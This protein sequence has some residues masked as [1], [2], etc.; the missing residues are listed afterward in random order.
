[1][2]DFEKQFTLAFFT[3]Y[4]RILFENKYVDKLNSMSLSKRVKII[5][6]I[7]QKYRSVTYGSTGWNIL[8]VLFHY[9]KDYGSKMKNEVFSPYRHEVYCIDDK[10]VIRNVYSSTQHIDLYTVEEYNKEIS[11]KPLNGFVTIG[12]LINA[13]RKLDSSINIYIDYKR[14]PDGNYTSIHLDRYDGNEIIPVYLYD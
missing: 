8:Q 14:S 10:F 11:V 2:S 5:N 9:A 12:N 6:N 3:E 7:R 13:L 4:K 1:M